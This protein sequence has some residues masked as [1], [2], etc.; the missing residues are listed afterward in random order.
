MVARFGPTVLRRVA[1]TPRGLRPEREG[2]E[3][4]VGREEGSGK[5]RESGALWVPRT[6]R[7]RRVRL[8]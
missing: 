2:L 8:S 6:R 3:V 5:T 4:A 1:A 7:E